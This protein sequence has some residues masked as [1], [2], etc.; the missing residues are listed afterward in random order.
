MGWHAFPD[1]VTDVK[2]RTEMLDETI[3]ILTLMYQR[4]QFDYDGRHYHLKLTQLDLMH[5][6]P[7]PIQQPRIPMWVPGAWPRMR[8]MRRLLKCDG[9]LPLKMNDQGGFDTVTP[10][11][12][13]KM[14][15]YI[16]AN[17]TLTTPFDYVV[18]GKTGELEP[19]EATAKVREWAE[20]G[21]T[22]W[23]ES[24]WEATREQ[25]EARLRKGPPGIV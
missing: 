9:L 11:D 22:W 3:D 2:T 24:L 1:E 18:E 25:A 16:D 19:S 12:L 10:D 4:K 8:S 20:A 17:R 14:K 21:A 13:G 5:Y 15:A 23:I 6:P 7:K